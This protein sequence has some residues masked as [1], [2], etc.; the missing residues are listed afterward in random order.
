MYSK[1]AVSAEAWVGQT[2]SSRSSVLMVAKKDSPTALSQH[3]PLRPWESRTPS[4]VAAAANWV[5]VYWADSSGRR[6]TSIMEVL[7]GRPAGWMKELTGRAPMKSPGK[8]SLRRD[9][10]RLFWREIAR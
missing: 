2:P 9:V 7:M 4:S 10:E 6:N 3:W 5:E 1:I 8:P